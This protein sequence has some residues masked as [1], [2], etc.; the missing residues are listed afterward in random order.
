[1]ADIIHAYCSTCLIIDSAPFKVCCDEHITMNT[2]L[3][4]SH[5][6]GNPNCKNCI[7]QDKSLINIPHK[8][9]TVVKSVGGYWTKS[10]KININNKT[11]GHLLVDHNREDVVLNVVPKLPLLLSNYEFAD[12]QNDGKEIHY[13]IEFDNAA[14][15]IPVKRIRDRWLIPSIFEITQSTKDRCKTKPRGTLVFP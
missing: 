13:F 1:M 4:I 14:Y 2:Y 7:L 3:S 12:V 5:N 10:D 11:L 8:I 15:K 9:G 6:A